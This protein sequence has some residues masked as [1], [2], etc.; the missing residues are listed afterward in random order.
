MNCTAVFWCYIA[1]PNA[2]HVSTGKGMPCS[3]IGHQNP[4]PPAAVWPSTSY[5]QAWSLRLWPT[6]ALMMGLLQ[7]PQV[8]VPSTCSTFPFRPTPG[9]GNNPNID[10][11]T[12]KAQPTVTSHLVHLHSLCKTGSSH[13][14]LREVPGLITLSVLHSCPQHLGSVWVPVARTLPTHMDLSLLLTHPT[15][16]PG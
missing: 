14:V 15:A 2:A 9:F 1:D 3:N 6:T 5:P 4:I 11:R 7:A 10:P 8:F 13:W 12:S 16:G